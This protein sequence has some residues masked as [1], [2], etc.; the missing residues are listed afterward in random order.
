MTERV[1]VQPAPFFAHYSS[2]FRHARMTV[3]QVSEPARFRKVDKVC[4]FERQRE[5][6]LPFFLT[7]LRYYDFSRWSK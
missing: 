3:S 2:I 7:S 6:F 1:T 4:H 5:I